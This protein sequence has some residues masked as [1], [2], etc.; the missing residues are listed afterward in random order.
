MPTIVDVRPLKAFARRKLRGYP[1]LCEI[2][3]EEDEFVAAEE[4]IVRSK[5]WLRLVAKEHE[6]RDS[7]GLTPPYNRFLVR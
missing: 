3:L 6:L 4:F 2:I 1:M 5:I 7:R